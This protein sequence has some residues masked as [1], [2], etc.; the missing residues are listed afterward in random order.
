MSTNITSIDTARSIVLE[1]SSMLT[2]IYHSELDGFVDGEGNVQI[3]S[4]T[5]RD[6]LA[7]IRRQLDSVSDML[8]I[9]SNDLK[10]SG[11]SA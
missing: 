4:G 3:D 6:C 5:I 1:S 8:E 10:R 9:V 11:G 7:M 2:M